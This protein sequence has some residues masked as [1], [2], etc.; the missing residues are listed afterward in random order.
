MTAS[1]LVLTAVKRLPHPIEAQAFLAAICEGEGG[2]RPNRLYGG[3]TL[4]QPANPNVGK[5][6]KGRIWTG[7]LDTFPDWGGSWL[8]ANGSGDYSTAAGV[9]QFTQTTWRRISSITGRTTFGIEDQLENGWW[10]ASDDFIRRSKMQ[11]LGRLQ[12]GSL[13]MIS[14][15]LI[16]TWPGGAS[17]T[18]PKRYA[19]NLTALPTPPSPGPM[20]PD[21]NALY[22]IS[23]TLEM[24]DGRPVSITVTLRPP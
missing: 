18:F 23:G 8:S 24:K 6:S 22:E 9:L 20:P 7:S 2:D 12:S 21:P 17:S 16:K 10:L 1:P 11:L 19:A 3:G 15:Y 5:D 13:D 14:T 4:R